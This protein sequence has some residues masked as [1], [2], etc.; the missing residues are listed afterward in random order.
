MES[1]SRNNTY[2]VV[3]WYHP[4]EEAAAFIRLY[5]KDVAGVIVVDNSETDNRHLLQCEEVVYLPQGKNLGIGAALNIG[6]REALQ[7]GATWVLTMDQDSQWNQ[8]SVAQYMTEVNQYDGFA[9]VALFSPFHDC[10]G[11]PERHHLNGR[12]ETREVVMCSGNLLRL[13]SWKEVG[14]FNEDFFIDYVDDEMCHRL[15]AHH[16]Q[17]VRA[18]TILLTH[19]LGNGV[20]YIG[21]RHH[22]Y[23]PHPVWRYFY[24]ARNIH[25]LMR[26]YPDAAPYYRSQRRKYLKR[27]WLYDWHDKWAKLREFRR[28]WREA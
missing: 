7:R 19:S 13:S 23:I 4:Q 20:K 24:I 21:W 5:K 25:R 28:G 12:F 2:A 11:H 1:V 10:D 17:V 22:P 14:G 15:N 16:W 8:H 27:L 9:Q 26:M 3:V 18:N 6:C